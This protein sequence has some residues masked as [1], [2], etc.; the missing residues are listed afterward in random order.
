MQQQVT[1]EWPP[2]FNHMSTSKTKS[3]SILKGTSVVG[4]LTLLSR[5]LGFVRDLL[6]ANL[7]GTGLFAD[8]FVVAFRIP[9]LLRSIFAEG[10][11]T[12]GFVPSFAEARVKGGDHAKRAFSD[13]FIVLT[14][15]TGIAT[16]LGVFAAEWI[17]EFFAPGF[18]AE[19][20]K[21]ALVTLLTKIMFPYIIFVSW[22]ALIN[23]ALNAF[24]VFGA[25]PIAQIIV[26]V[27]SIIGVSVGYFFAQYWA[28][29][30]IAIFVL[31]GGFAE[32]VGLIPYLR[33]EGL[34]LH[35]GSNP[36]SPVVKSTM[37]L[38]VPA[39]I[40][41]AVYQ[42]IIFLNVN[43]ASLLAE[44][45]VSWL[46]YADRLAQLPIGVFTIALASVLLPSL[47]LSY[48]RGDRLTFIKDID[49]S[50]RFTVFFIMP[51]SG[52]LWVTAEP[53][54]ALLFERGKFNHSSTQMTALALQ[55]YSFGLWSSSCYS[56]LIRG[57]IAQKKV[58]VP[59]YVGLISLLAS[60]FFS[61]SFM[62]K[63]KPVKIGFW[64]RSLQDS[65]PMVLEFG[66]AGL[67]LS[68]S[69]TSGV[70]LL[71]LSA[72][73]AY[74]NSDFSLKSVLT[75]SARTGIATL[76]AVVATIMYCSGIEA[77]LLAVLARS[78][79][80]LII[81]VIVSFLLRSPEIKETRTLFMRLLNKVRKRTA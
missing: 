71:A 78:S 2:H 18:A 11:F 14:L 51:I 32:I 23:G 40:G 4:S 67:A 41:G 70:S 25:G 7:L 75:A 10:A 59:T 33:K 5:L 30:I 47:S 1:S 42:L 12:A 31:V 66:H 34:R 56:M 61:L 63:V 72:L 36:F 81:F 60:V 8:A 54:V 76:G 68:S 50:L 58:Q 16:L 28:T 39:L 55:G 62:G 79:S 65:L 24:G 19:P 13:V 37:R 22:V 29:L 45:S 44:G 57:F 38:M 64:I 46:Y 15:F 74:F 3:I 48:A 6:M 20:E 77:P 49:D 35:F 9:N 26:N 43:F 80:V 27:A 21:A 73:F 52:V 53:L 69:I 17:T